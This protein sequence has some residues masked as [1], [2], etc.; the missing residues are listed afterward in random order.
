[1]LDQLLAIAGSPLTLLYAAGLTLSGLGIVGELSV[2]GL[3]GRPLYG[4]KDTLANLAMYAGY[5]ALNMI[6]AHG[7]FAVYAWASQHAVAHVVIGG[8]HVGQHG[9]AW[10]WVLLIV[11]EDL[12]FYAFHRAS[13]RVR[14]LWASHV[15]HHSSRKYNLSVAFRQTWVP[16]LGVAFWL[17]LPLI[18]FDPL[19]IMS[20]QVISLFYQEL[21]HTQ[22]VP[23]LGPIEWI[24]NT[25]RHHAVHHG[26]N[27]AYLDR[28][29]G[30]I[31][32]VWDRLFGTFAK[33][34]EPVRFGLTQDLGSHNPIVIAGHEWW[35]MVTDVWRQPGVIAKLAAVFAP[36]RPRAHRSVPARTARSGERHLAMPRVVSEPTE[37]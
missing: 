32:I 30:G 18:G 34:R 6:W 3:T 12:C 25:P 13:H 16:F 14:I 35:A 26:S 17:P 19:M 5:F 22:L 9:L 8:W 11:L 10:E 23:R 37:V 7:I 31:L 4:A 29:Y 28:N 27:P 21:L 33:Q 2:A 24:F 20:V 1:M 36:P 15:T